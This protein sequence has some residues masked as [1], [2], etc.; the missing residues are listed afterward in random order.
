MSSSS[1]APEADHLDAIQAFEALASAIENI[2]P[3]EQRPC[4]T[5]LLEELQFRFAETIG[6]GNNAVACSRCD[7]LAAHVHERYRESIQ[8]IVRLLRISHKREPDMN[9]PIVSQHSMDHRFHQCICSLSIESIILM[10]G[11]D[12]PKED[13]SALR[14][15]ADI[16]SDRVSP[17]P[18]R[19]SILES[20][21]FWESLAQGG[22]VSALLREKLFKKTE[23][24]SVAGAP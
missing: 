2:E 22:D 10:G 16:V 12:D 11:A 17:G 15:I 6:G 3:P 13:A 18:L 21:D 14:E 20:R 5:R 9:P 19:Q 4:L 8:M 1:P 23:R 24:V 7:V